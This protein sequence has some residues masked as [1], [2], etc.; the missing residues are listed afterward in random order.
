M[1]VFSASATSCASLSDGLY[2]PCSRKTMV[3]LR[4]PTKFAS[5]SWVMFSLARNS[6]ILFSI[7]FADSSRCGKV[8]RSVF[9]PI[10]FFADP[11]VLPGEGSKRY[12]DKEKKSDRPEDEVHISFG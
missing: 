8:W 9:D 7:L 3:S 11:A 12:N 4:A 10:A 2:L 5:C 1:V 6:L